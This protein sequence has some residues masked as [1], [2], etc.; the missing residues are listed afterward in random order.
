MREC[1]AC[2]AGIDRQSK[3][4]VPSVI[5][6]TFRCGRITFNSTHR[7][8]HAKKNIQAIMAYKDYV[9]HEIGQGRRLVGF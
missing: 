4:C 3:P 8:E 7:T 5:S 6:M 2:L 1:K 9:L